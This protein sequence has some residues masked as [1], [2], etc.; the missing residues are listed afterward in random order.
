MNVHGRQGRLLWKPFA[1]LA[2][3]DYR[4]LFLG[5]TPSPSEI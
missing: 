3:T 4:L 5:I 2:G 1:E